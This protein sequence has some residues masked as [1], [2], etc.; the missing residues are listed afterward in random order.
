MQSSPWLTFLVVMALMV[1]SKAPGA[2]DTICPSQPVGV[3]EVGD[4]SSKQY[5]AVAKAVPLSSDEGSYILAE[6]EARLEAR[7]A[8][9]KHLEPTVSKTKFHGLVDARTCRRGSDV[10]ATVILNEANLLKAKKFQ[11]LLESSF[12]KYPTP[13]Q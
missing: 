1:A 9:M 8:L 10:Y 4:G 13:I 11:E 6:A 12:N 3:H 2:E 5:L 7:R